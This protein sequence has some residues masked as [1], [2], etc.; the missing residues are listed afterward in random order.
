[1]K[2][3]FLK[4][5]LT[6][7]ILFSISNVYANSPTDLNEKETLPEELLNDL[8]LVKLQLL[9]Q[10]ALEQYQMYEDVIINNYF[11]S[12][13]NQKSIETF[14][15]RASSNNKVRQY[16]KDSVDM[17]ETYLTPSEVAQLYDAL[18]AP[19]IKK[20]IVSSLMGSFSSPFGLTGILQDYTVRDPLYKLK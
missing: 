11:D 8:T 15:L 20:S 3:N 5:L 17:R 12:S 6:F 16:R 9:E 1:M 14:Q 10:D 4:I 13:D 2:A 19:D 7:L 18:S